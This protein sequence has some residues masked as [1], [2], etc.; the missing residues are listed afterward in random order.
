[1]LHIFAKQVKAYVHAAHGRQKC[2]LLFDPGEMKLLADYVAHEPGKHLGI[3]KRL[4]EN[5]AVSK[6]DDLNHGPMLLGPV[7]ERKT[8]LVTIHFRR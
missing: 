8:N 3:R 7:G 6:R 1:M 4:L 5:R 2:L